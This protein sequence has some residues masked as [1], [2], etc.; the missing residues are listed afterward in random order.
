MPIP[1]IS[2]Q[3]KQTELGWY[4]TTRYK[5]VNY[6]QAYIK[7]QSLSDAQIDFREKVIQ[8]SNGEWWKV[9]RGN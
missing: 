8:C 7:G 9:V 5:G 6:G 1:Q 2:I 3:S 4:L